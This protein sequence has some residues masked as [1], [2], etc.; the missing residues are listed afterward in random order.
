M[1]KR[2]QVTLFMLLGVLVLLAAGITLFFILQ[3]EEATLDAAQPQDPLPEQA[4]LQ[5]FV[6]SCA[7]QTLD[8]ALRTLG[9]NGGHL[10]RPSYLTLQYTEDRVIAVLYA[11]RVALLPT[12]ELIQ[13][14]LA[15][16]LTENLRYCLDD[17]APYEEQGWNVQ[18]AGV[19]ANLTIT[20]ET[21]IAHVFFP[22]TIARG[23]HSFILAPARAQRRVALPLML[24]TVE[25]ILADVSMLQQELDAAAATRSDGNPGNDRPP[26][27]EQLPRTFTR[28]GIRITHHPY[29]HKN[30]I[31][32]RVS[33]GTL[34]WYFA[35]ALEAP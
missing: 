11:K 23:N 5:S 16:Y 26:R 29:P 9:E 3:R 12:Y 32:W 6:Q 4:A 7:E 2:G 15:R 34:D 21:L 8:D 33:D 10:T 1:Q 20:N 28:N 30:N 14:G 22:A 17:L 25:R 31:L 27:I 35:T 19:A 13:E 18:L 24:A